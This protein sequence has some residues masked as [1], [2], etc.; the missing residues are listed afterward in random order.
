M[1]ANHNDNPS[2]SRIY[3]VIEGGRLQ[4]VEEADL[5]EGDDIVVVETPNGVI[6]VIAGPSSV[7][8]RPT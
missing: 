5:Q 8:P 4:E 7:A 6:L 3:R 1:S 2:I